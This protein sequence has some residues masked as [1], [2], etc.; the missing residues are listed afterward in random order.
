MYKELRFG[1]I[2]ETIATLEQRIKERFPDSGLS[3]VCAEFCTTSREA[4]QEITRLARPNRW[5]RL[6][7]ATALILFFA[8]LVFT[9]SIVEWEYSKPNLVEVIQITEALINDILLLGA[10]LFFLITIELRLKR[11]RALKALHQLRSVA[12]VVD[13]HQLTKDPSM[14]GAQHK[15]T[16]NSPKRTMTQFELQRYLDYCSELF[17]LIGKIAALYSEK[18]PEPEIVSAAADIEDLCTGLSQKVWQKMV[19][20][21]VDYPS[22][23]SSYA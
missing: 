3:K 19:F 18:L 13:M 22:K 8:T 4:E 14:L 16:P 9:L 6:G 12:H 21:D 15:P 1:K 2:V 23:E 11:Q 7:V 20:L 17:S 5:I 10:A